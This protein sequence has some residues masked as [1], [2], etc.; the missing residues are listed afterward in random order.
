MKISFYPIGIVRLNSLSDDEAT[1][2]LK[3]SN[4]KTSLNHLKFKAFSCYKEKEKRPL[5]RSSA[6]LWLLTA[7]VSAVHVRRSGFLLYVGKFLRHTFL[8]VCLETILATLFHFSSTGQTV[9][10]SSVS[11]YSSG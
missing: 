11:P 6:K 7:V 3:S 2:L 4:M 1:I 10:S 5:M 8:T 9:S